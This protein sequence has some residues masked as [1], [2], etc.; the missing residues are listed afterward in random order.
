M[1]KICILN[2][3]DVMPRGAKLLNP[4]VVTVKVLDPI[5][6]DDWTKD[7]ME[8]KI[9]EV[10]NLYLRELGQYEIGTPQKQ[11]T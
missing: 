1:Y 10:R 7:N 4:T 3:H 8:D 5:S 2:A 6:V 11:L 9:R